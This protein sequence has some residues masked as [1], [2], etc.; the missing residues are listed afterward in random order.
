VRAE[1]RGEDGLGDAEAE[2]AAEELEEGGEGGGLA[3]EVG[4]VFE[5]DS[6]YGG[7]R[8]LEG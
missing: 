6:V 4:G 2:G 3:E 1:G 8:V 7:R 5:F